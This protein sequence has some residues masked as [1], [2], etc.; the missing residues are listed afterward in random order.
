MAE[1]SK[2]SLLYDARED[3]LIVDTED[4]EG[5]TTRLWLTQRLCRGLVGALVPMLEKAT[6]SHMPPQAEEAVQSWE[7]AAAMQDFGKTPGVK[8]Q[9]DAT[10][11]LVHTVHISPG[12]DRIVLTFV[13]V[14]EETR[15][16]GVTHQ[17]LRQ[18]LSVMH[19]LYVAA[20]WPREGWPDWIADPAALAPVGTVN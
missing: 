14:G 9:A 11:G 12:E 6:A 4:A 10:A 13:L 16:I 2:F 7:Q 17:A 19:N 15:A 1:I 8:V 5:G 3:R 18:T 20:G